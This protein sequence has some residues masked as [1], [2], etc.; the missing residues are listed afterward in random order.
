M[1]KKRTN[2]LKCVVIWWDVCDLLDANGNQNEIISGDSSVIERL[3]CDL[4]HCLETE[5]LST[6]NRLSWPEGQT[7]VQELQFV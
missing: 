7:R 2:V 4:N 6:Q 3:S 5:Q 1:K